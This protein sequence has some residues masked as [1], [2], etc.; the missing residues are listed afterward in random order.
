MSLFFTVLIHHSR[1]KQSCIF[2]CKKFSKKI[3]LELWSTGMLSF[4]LIVYKC[5]F[6]LNI[7][8]PGHSG[9]FFKTR[10]RI[11]NRHLTKVGVHEYFFLYKFFLNWQCLQTHLCFFMS[12]TLI[13]LQQKCPDVWRANHCDVTMMLHVYWHFRWGQKIVVSNRRHE[14]ALIIEAL[15]GTCS[16][17]KREKEKTSILRV[18]T[19]QIWFH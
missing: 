11:N 16:W 19:F 4:S 18:Q 3:F 10:K 7:F 9:F 1:L 13:I 2:V 15:T 14:L 17:R 12:G 5:F 8:A 6:F